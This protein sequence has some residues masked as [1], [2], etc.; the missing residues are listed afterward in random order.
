MDLDDL[1]AVYFDPDGR[2]KSSPALLCRAEPQKGCKHWSMA[3][4]S[5]KIPLHRRLSL[6]WDTDTTPEQRSD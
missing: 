1:P 4:A 5:P 2:D 3:R 6:N